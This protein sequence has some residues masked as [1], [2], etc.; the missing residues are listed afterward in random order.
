MQQFP[1]LF[2]GKEEEKEQNVPSFCSGRELG[3]RLLSSLSSKAR[4]QVSS[5]SGCN[6]A[7]CTEIGVS[8]TESM[9]LLLPTD[10]SWHSSLPA[11]WYPFHHI[12]PMRKPK[13]AATTPRTSPSAQ[14]PLCWLVSVNQFPGSALCII[15]PNSPEAMFYL[16]N[17]SLKKFLKVPF[18]IIWSGGK[19]NLVFFLSSLFSPPLS[20]I[21]VLPASSWQC[22]GY[23]SY[24]LPRHECS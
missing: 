5:R 4:A 7:V 15:F 13:A 8:P 10:S 21:P 24:S 9:S 1:S 2:F 11:L 22:P 3:G 17:L 6:T 18:E 20:K 12:S 19:P 23:L 16:Y 14:T